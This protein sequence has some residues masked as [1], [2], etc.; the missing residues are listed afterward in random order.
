MAATTV[1]FGAAFRDKEANVANAP[2]LFLT[3]TI[4]CSLHTSTYS[5]NVDSNKFWSDTTNEVSSANYTTKGVA[6]TTKTIT[7]DSASNETRYD[8]DDEAWTTV[9]FTTRHGIFFKDTGTSSTSP[10]MW[11]CDFGGDQTVSGANFTIQNAAT[12]IAKATA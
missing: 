12:G 7:Y 1:W 11:W 3:D 4:K 8:A 9:T 2:W 5:P 6:L 10:L